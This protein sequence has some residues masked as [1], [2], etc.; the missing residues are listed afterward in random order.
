MVQVSDT[1]V[2]VEARPE[3][4]RLEPARTAVIVVDL[5]NGYVSPGGYRDLNGRDISGAPRA[6]ENT[7][8]VLE[9]ARPAGLTVVLLQ[10]GWDPALREGGG[11]GS[12]SWHKS[13]PLKLMRERPQLAGKILTRGGWDYALVDALKPAPTDLIV[14]KAR[15]SGFSGTNLDTLLRERDIRTL[16]FTGIATNVCVESTLREAYFR[17]Y[18]C[19][20]VEDAVQQAGPQFIQDASVYNVENFLG[21][22][23]GTDD[24]CRALASR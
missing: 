3:A 6:V 1:F 4:I 24:I 19:I 5:Q 10:N 17:E 18:F 11:E 8:R 23:A 2:V 12:P 16:V 22:V 15:Y 13:N 14:S 9:V 7:L 21:W 20:L